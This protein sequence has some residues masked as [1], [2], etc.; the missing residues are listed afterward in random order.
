[1]ATSSVHTN[2]PGLAK[3]YLS[4]VRDYYEDLYE[5]A[6]EEEENWR[7]ICEIRLLSGVLH[8]SLGNY[9][10]AVS[11][12]ES[13]SPILNK[14]IESDPENLEYQAMLSVLYT[15]LGV[16]H[17]SAGE[18]EKSKDVFEKSLPINTRLLEEEPENFLYMTGLVVTFTEYS[19]LLTTLGRKEEAEEYADK[20]DKLKE[21]LT[22]KYGFGKFVNEYEEP[23]KEL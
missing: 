7:A 12:Y 22:K 21:S 16:A 3:E 14:Q 13:I 1:M 15:Q 23:E 19:K 17:Y 10:A 5:K 2:L 8:E 20:A 4:L 6:P 11:M 9:D 18:Y